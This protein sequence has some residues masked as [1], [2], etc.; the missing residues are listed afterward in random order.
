MVESFN[1]ERAHVLVAAVQSI[2]SQMQQ[3]RSTL[4]ADLQGI[5]TAAA[6]A[7]SNVREAAAASTASVERGA[8]ELRSGCDSLAAAAKSS[9][10]MGSAVLP[11]LQQA[12]SDLH[13]KLGSASKAI[14]RA[15]SSAASNVQAA[16]AA[17][18]QHMSSNADQVHTAQGAVLQV[19]EQQHA[20]DMAVASSI[21]QMCSEA[22][23]AMAGEMLG[24][25]AWN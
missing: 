10:A 20:A 17:A 22:S 2:Q 14:T 25:N 18:T 12:Q 13:N 4:S 9:A 15:T 21:T 19:L 16:A 6:N 1:K 23:D 7:A 5:C 24:H 11:K 3:D 8:A